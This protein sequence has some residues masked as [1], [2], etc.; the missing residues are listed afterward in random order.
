MWI[1]AD[2]LG[3]GF[4]VSVYLANLRIYFFLATKI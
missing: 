1:A 4:G 3:G 2:A